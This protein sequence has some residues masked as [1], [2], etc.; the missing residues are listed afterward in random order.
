MYQYLV[1]SQRTYI[2]KLLNSCKDIIKDNTV[3]GL[4]VTDTS[5]KA[6]L[7]L[8]SMLNAR[9]ALEKDTY[10]LPEECQTEDILYTIIGISS[11]YSFLDVDYKGNW[12]LKTQF[13]DDIF[14]TKYHE[15]VYSGSSHDLRGIQNFTVGFQELYKFILNTY[16]GI[17]M[18]ART[19]LT[20]DITEFRVSKSYIEDLVVKAGM[21]FVFDSSP[22]FASKY[23]W[24]T[25]EE[26]EE[27]TDRLKAI[28]GLIV[29]VSANQ[30]SVHISMSFS[31]QSNL[32]LHR[33]ELYV[34]CENE[35]GFPEEC[36]SSFLK[37]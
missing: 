16:S 22:V 14:S 4:K 31:S 27:I 21:E 1:E 32:Y 15:C 2:T 33:E 28:D 23:L 10:K 13:F 34:V 24:G 35:S 37:Y 11:R 25:L 7:C 18:N 26:Y 6:T 19:L 30:M 29:R 12:V 3:L 20:N 8:V 5:L 17:Q 9:L 36:L